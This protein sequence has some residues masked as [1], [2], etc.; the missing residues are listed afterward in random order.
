MTYDIQFTYIHKHM[1]K[2]VH[3]LCITHKIHIVLRNEIQ[4]RLILNILQDM[5]I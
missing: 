1:Y 3:T 5:Q 2:F 4:I